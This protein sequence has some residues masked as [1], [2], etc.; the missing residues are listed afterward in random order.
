MP[1]GRRRKPRVADPPSEPSE[2]P[3]P[4]SAESNSDEAEESQLEDEETPSVKDLLTALATGMRGQVDQTFG[5]FGRTC[6][7]DESGL[8]LD[9]FI[10]VLVSYKVQQGISDNDALRQLPQVL[11]GAA[12][13]WWMTV[14]K[15]SQTWDEAL[16]SLRETFGVIKPDVV[17]LEQLMDA[18]QKPGQSVQAFLADILAVN[19]RRKRPLGETLLVEFVF[20]GLRPNLQ[21]RIKV[22]EI[23]TVNDLRSKAAAVE[24]DLARAQRIQRDRVR[25]EGTS[26]S[27]TTLGVP[28]KPANRFN[29]PKTT[30]GQ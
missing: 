1:R 8:L 4:E 9:G 25:R 20:L 29:P 10:E 24:V 21:S 15:T 30:V 28:A 19:G 11:G 17:L 26:Q 18:R 12:L 7:G 13:T 14:G 6:T 27:A 2:S 16:A 5:R 3:P 22:E 23:A